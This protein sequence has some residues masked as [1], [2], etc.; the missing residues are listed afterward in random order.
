MKGSQVKDF[1]EFAGFRLNIKKHRLMFG[2]HIVS[3]TPKEFSLLLFLIEHAGRVVEKDELLETIWKDTFVE[4]GTLTRNVSWLRKKLAAYAGNDAAIIETLPK[5]G[6]RFVPELSKSEDDLI[7]EEQTVQ[8]IQIEEI[9]EIESSPN[10]NAYTQTF[11][12]ESKTI[13]DAGFRALPAAPAGRNFSLVWILPVLLI[14]IIAVIVVYNGYFSPKQTKIILASKIAPFSGLPGRE[15]FPAFS[16]DGKQLV[17]SWDGNVEEGSSDI[18]IKLIGTG[19]P[20]R[21]TDTPENEINP[22]FSPDGKSIAFVR[23]FPTHNEIILIP[24]LGGAERK[25]YDQASY[26]SISFS[27]DGKFLAHANLDASQN[28]AGIFLINLQNGEKTKLTTPNSPVVDH[29]PRFS[30]DGKF[31]AFIRY[32]SSFQ[33]EVFMVP[34]TGGEARRITS[35]DT[36]IYGLSWSA[37]S[38]KLLFTSFRTVNQL[39]LWQI[40]LSGDEPPEM[41]PT[42]SKNLESV[43]ISPDGKI[44]A[45]VEENA[46]ENIWLS[47][48]NASPRPLIRSIRADHSQQF[49]PDGKQIVFVSDRTGNYEIWLAD[50][51]GKNQRPLTDKKGSAGSPRFSPDGK[52]IVYDTQSAGKSDIYIISVNGGEARRLTSDDKNNCLPAWSTDGQ[53]IFFLTN[54]SGSDQIWKMPVP[55][56]GEAVQIT[57]QGAFEMF[58]A[59]DGKNIFYSKGGGKA[60]LWQVDTE[61]REEK[62]IPELSEIGSW[63]SWFVASNGIYYTASANQ[64]P[65]Q[66]KFFDFSTRQTKNIIKTE[67]PPLTYYSNLS[68]SAEGNKILYARQDQSTDTIFLAE[69]EESR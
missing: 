22:V 45:F 29:T 21:L 4:E 33:R 19:E 24:A 38:R 46:D 13:S 50:A 30:P 8:H 40:S 65:Y 16:P 47:E 53:W 28:D 9:I 58:A 1:Y 43:A 11:D 6:Y 17:Y 35:D 63:R 32:F 39:N 59:P 56:G 14:S 51:D 36:R 23:V 20:V 12:T 55:G 15:Q 69:F 42:G 62:P 27:P 66:I 18:Y 60:G 37:D 48:A 10:E 57:R 7:I 26:A 44:I 49:S 31:L 67:K 52:F 64:P 25:I 54:R 3:L 61:G 5:L 34:A 2:D 68:V 41:I